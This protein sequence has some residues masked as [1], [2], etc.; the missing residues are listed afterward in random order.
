[1]KKSKENTLLQKNTTAA[2]AFIAKGFAVTAA[3]SA[4]C[5]LY[6]QPPKPDL[7]SL[8]KF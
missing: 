8:R 7:K 6:H 3:N 1:M 5:C 4:C 2:L